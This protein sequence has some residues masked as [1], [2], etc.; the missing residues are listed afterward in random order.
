MRRPILT[1]DV[2]QCLVLLRL[3]DGWLL[4]TRHGLSLWPD[5]QPIPNCDRI[6][7]CAVSRSELDSLLVQPTEEMLDQRLMGLTQWHEASLLV[8]NAWEKSIDRAA[9]QIPRSWVPRLVR[10]GISGHRLD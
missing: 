2:S 10:P 8:P 4:T 6:Y 9:E 1:S 3:P 5:P 7:D